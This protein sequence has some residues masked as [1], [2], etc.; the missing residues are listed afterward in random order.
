MGVL[1]KHEEL[2]DLGVVNS[3][4]E[5]VWRDE[6]GALGVEFVTVDLKMPIG[7]RS[8]AQGKLQPVSKTKFACLTS[9]VDG[10]AEGRS[11]RYDFTRGTYLLFGNRVQVENNSPEAH[12]AL[13]LCN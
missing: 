9:R 11:Y 4:P 6:V 10:W 3:W 5:D 7:T 1:G 2:R 13:N 12:S 8:N